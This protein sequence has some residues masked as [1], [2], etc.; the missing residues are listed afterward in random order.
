[1]SMFRYSSI[2]ILCAIATLTSTAFAQPGPAQPGPEH[3]IVKSGEGTWDCVVKIGDQQTKAT[4]TSK[5]ALGGLWLITEFKGSIEGQSF[6]GHGIDG[7][8]LD[9]KKYTSVWVDSM[10]SSVMQFEGTYDEKTKT[11]TS[12][13]EG[14]GP[15]GKP[16]KYKGVTTHTDKDHQVFKMYLVQGD[17]ENLMMTIEYTRK[18]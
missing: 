12:Y 1:M 16:A 5:S 8:D 4:S 6:E 15:D 2:G 10:T 13:S 7:Y 17:Q 9:K 14:K 18:K 11:I 3:A